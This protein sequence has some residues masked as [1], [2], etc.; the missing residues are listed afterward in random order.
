MLRDVGT[1]DMLLKP[2]LQWLAAQ[3]KG[4]FEK[5]TLS[6]VRQDGIIGTERGEGER[7][8][9]EKRN[10]FGTAFG[11]GGSSRVVPKSPGIL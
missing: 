2:T 7:E 8:K 10:V 6:S 5:Q 3:G 4:P 1:V 11:Q 9:K